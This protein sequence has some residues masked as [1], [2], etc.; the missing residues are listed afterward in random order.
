MQIHQ[1]TIH[2]MQMLEIVVQDYQKVKDQC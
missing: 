1:Y 2:V